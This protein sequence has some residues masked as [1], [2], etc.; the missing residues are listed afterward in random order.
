MS[1]GKGRVVVL[2]EA[3]MLSAQLTGPGGMKFGMNHPGIDNRQL[4]LNIVHWLSGL[5]K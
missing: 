3:A 5:L 2:G 4:A 1:F